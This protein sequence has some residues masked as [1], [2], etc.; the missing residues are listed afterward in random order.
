[1]GLSCLGNEGAVWVGA[2]H[3]HVQVSGPPQDQGRGL[4]PDGGGGC[5]GASFCTVSPCDTPLCLALPSARAGWGGAG[6]F[7]PP[8]G[9]RSAGHW[10][11]GGLTPAGLQGAV[12]GLC[13]AEA[14]N[15]QGKRFK[16]QTRHPAMLPRLLGC[17]EVTLASSLQTPLGPQQALWLWRRAACGGCCCQRTCSDVEGSPVQT[18]SGQ[19]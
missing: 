18:G 15:K 5:G 6:A 16:G 17:P 2:V 19:A 3:S 9:L 4:Q 10:E 11:W 12:S 8:P 14:Q 1:M 7:R 13:P